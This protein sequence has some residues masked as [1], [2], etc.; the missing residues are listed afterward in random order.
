MA[1]IGVSITKRVSFRGSTQEFS[2]T[3]YYGAAQGDPSV[4]DATAMINELVTSEKNL[5]GS[6]VTFVHARLWS[7]GGTPAQ[8]QM[9]HEMALTGAGVRPADAR[10]D[11]ERAVLAQWP[12]GVDSRGKQVNLRKWYHVCSAAPSGA[13]ISDGILANT[14]GWSDTDRTDWANLI[15]PV[16]RIGSLEAW[17]LVSPTGRERNGGPPVVHRYFEHHQLGDQWRG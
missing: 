6:P 1:R 13:P 17:G 4:A 16:T 11:R 3:Y 9:I 12:A 10:V 15:D 5:H 8:N 2:N 14:A 7:A